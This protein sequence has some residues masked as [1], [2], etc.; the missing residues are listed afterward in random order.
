VEFGP[1]FGGFNPL[2]LIE[3]KQ[4][5]GIQRKPTIHFVQNH[6]GCTQNL[7]NNVLN[8]F[9]RRI[10][11]IN[12]SGR[13]FGVHRRFFQ[14]KRYEV[15]RQKA[16]ESRPVKQMGVTGSEEEEDILETFY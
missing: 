5:P 6:L 9:S 7:V 3:D 4:V 1:S 10:L 11:S 12:S 16:R 13:S 2:I 15:E 8:W 14:D